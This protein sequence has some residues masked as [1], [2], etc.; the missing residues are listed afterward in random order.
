MRAFF[1]NFIISIF[2]LIFCLIQFCIF[3]QTILISVLETNFVDGLGSYDETFRKE[4]WSLGDP[5]LSK[6]FQVTGNTDQNLYNQLQVLY[7]KVNSEI[8]NGIIFEGF[9]EN[10]E[11]NNLSMI[12][13]N[14]LTGYHFIIGLTRINYLILLYKHG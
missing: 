13:S 7:D 8:S 2:N 11:Q 14:T 4:F 9:P 1:L 10:I 3:L 6:Q 12:L 5:R